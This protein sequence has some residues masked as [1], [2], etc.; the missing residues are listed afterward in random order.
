MG[1]RHDF[2]YNFDRSSRMFAPQIF[3]CKWFPSASHFPSTNAEFRSILSDDETQG[4]ENWKFA[5]VMFPE[6]QTI[7]FLHWVASS[8]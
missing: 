8:A 3:L 6:T 1:K 7:L 4:L 5:Q 2:G